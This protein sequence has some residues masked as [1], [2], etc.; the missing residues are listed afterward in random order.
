MTMPA[1]CPHE[2]DVLDLV[3]TNQWPARA[4]R[5]LV[6]HVSTCDACRDLV[7][8]ASAIGGLHDAT[9]AAVK[10]PDASV[11]W[12]RAEVRARQELA[13]R[14]ARP[15]AAV[16]LA[17]G[18]LAVLG[19]MTGWRLGGSAFVDWWQTL[20]T[21]HPTGTGMWSAVAAFTSRPA[22]PWVLGA[23]AAWALMVPAALYIARMADRTP[24]P[25][26]DRP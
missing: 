1:S 21:V 10:V 12:Y 8:V 4:D 24:E 26:R 13:R 17:A 15:V 5:S 2:A 7:L 16:Q 19:L 20:P 11:V 3:W 9:A 14:A 25:T 22:W 23:V 18:V 6:A